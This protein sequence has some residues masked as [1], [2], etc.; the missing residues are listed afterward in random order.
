MK[1]NVSSIK[2]NVNSLM[3]LEDNLNAE[4]GH[5]VDCWT[6]TLNTHMTYWNT[7]DEIIGIWKPGNNEQYYLKNK[8][9][10]GAEWKNHYNN[11]TFGYPLS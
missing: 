3:E 6:G 2:V 5:D 7:N 4:W 8:K 9:L 1:N 10:L 11:V